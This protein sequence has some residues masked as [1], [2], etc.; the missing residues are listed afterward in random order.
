VVYASALDVS[1]ESMEEPSRTELDSHANIPVVGRN[2]YN[3][4]DT[5]R[6]ADVNPFTPDYDSMY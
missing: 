1:E 5:G 2:A 3:I 4:S 6:V